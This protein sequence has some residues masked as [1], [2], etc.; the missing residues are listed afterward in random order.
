MF[1]FLAGANN[2]QDARNGDVVAVDAKVEEGP[3][4]QDQNDANMEENAGIEQQLPQQPVGGDVEPP[5]D[6]AAL[7]GL[8]LHDGDANQEDLGANSWHPDTLKWFAGMKVKFDKAVLVTT[9]GVICGKFP[10][11]AME[12]IC[13]QDDPLGDVTL[14]G[15]SKISGSSGYLSI[16]DC[17]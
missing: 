15:R 10:A 8:F 12:E 1:E 6:K 17:C 9:S 4:Q 13:P 16:T 2:R 5:E 3:L 14:N 11:W 7:E